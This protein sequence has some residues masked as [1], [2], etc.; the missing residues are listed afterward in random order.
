MVVMDTLNRGY[1]S[2]TD[3]LFSQ[4]LLGNTKDLII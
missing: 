4:S 3:S 1:V 2:V